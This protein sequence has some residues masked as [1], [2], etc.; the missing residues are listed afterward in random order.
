[1]FI[2]SNIEKSLKGDDGATIVNTVITN[3][4]D[5]RPAKNAVEELK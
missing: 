2:K 1:L 3:F 4:Q 5:I